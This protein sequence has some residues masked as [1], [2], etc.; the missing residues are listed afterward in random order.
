[1][2]LG[3]EVDFPRCDLARTTGKDVLPF[4]ELAGQGW[5]RMKPNASIRSWRPA[6]VLPTDA[7]GAAARSDSP[8][9]TGEVI[10]AVAIGEKNRSVP[11]G[12]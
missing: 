12:P 11:S 3:S 10:D 7:D 2:T 1:V 5:Q 4:P 6:A 9:A 8:V